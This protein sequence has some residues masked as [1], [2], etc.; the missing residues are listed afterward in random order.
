MGRPHG[1][2]SGASTFH[3][4]D[5]AT[6]LLSTEYFQLCKSHLN[7]GGVIYVNTTDNDDVTFTA[8]IVCHIVS[9]APTKV[10]TNPSMASPTIWFTGPCGTTARKSLSSH[11][12]GRAGP[13]GPS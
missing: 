8:A 7:P 1:I 2:S 9:S 6:N 10:T 13:S 3:W 11:P 12:T 5:H 4:R